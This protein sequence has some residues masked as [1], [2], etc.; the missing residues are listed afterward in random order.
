MMKSIMTIRTVYFEV[1]ECNSIKKELTGLRR[2]LG[3]PLGIAL[4]AAARLLPRTLGAL[5]V[6]VFFVTAARWDTRRSSME[7]I[8]L[9]SI[10]ITFKDTR[11][12]RAW[13]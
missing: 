12:D 3:T 7:D 2:D 6:F 8:S 9:S 11:S 5:A 10:T 1:K 13:T 4:H